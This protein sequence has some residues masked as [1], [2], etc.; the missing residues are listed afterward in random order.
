MEI[1]SENKA[2]TNCSVQDGALQAKSMTFV[3]SY[4]CQ[5]I[6]GFILF[7]VDMAMKMAKC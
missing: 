6:K 7:S 2:I 1:F 4:L 5:N 3:S